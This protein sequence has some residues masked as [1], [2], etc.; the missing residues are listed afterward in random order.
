[1]NKSLKKWS[2]FRF[3]ASSSLHC[4]NKG[5]AI[6]FWGGGGG[7]GKGDGGLGNF[8]G[9]ENVFAFPG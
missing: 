2:L 5:H 3:A 8:G 4:F 9:H 6:F 1:M 7:G